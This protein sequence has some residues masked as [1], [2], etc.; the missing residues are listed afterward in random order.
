MVTYA[1]RPW[2]KNY[3]PGI[4]HTL[5]Y[6]P[7]PL[8]QFLSQAASK[9]PDNV[10]LITNIKLPVFGRVG[11]EM[12]YA[13]LDQQSDALAAALVEMGLQKG[14]RVAIV[15]PNVAAFVISFYA[16]LKAGGVVAAANP[17][18]PAEKLQFQI[19][20]CDAK[21]IITL[22]LFYKLVKSVQP[23]TKDKG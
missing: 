15:M 4:P 21:F 14:D 22:S 10:A 2:V 19:N 9:N 3:D 6:P 1:D 20:D 13:E 18:Y 5:E 8:H 23:K 11:S 12:T 16:I 17:T 7:V